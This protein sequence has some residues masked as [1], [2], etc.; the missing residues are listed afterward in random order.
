MG[1]NT[2]LVCGVKHIADV[3]LNTLLVCAAGADQG[4]GGEEPVEGG[5]GRGQQPPQGH[6][7][8]H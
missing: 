3:G 6:P 5:A 7:L 4:A 1:L 2:L 8:Q